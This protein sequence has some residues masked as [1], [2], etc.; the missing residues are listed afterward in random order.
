[1]PRTLTQ[2]IA[3]VRQE[4][5]TETTLHVTDAEI[6]RR[7]V[8]AQYELYDRML[9]VDRHLFATSQNF[10]LSSTPTFDLTTL[11]PSFYQ[12][13]GLE[14]VIGPRPLS[15]HRFQFADRNRKLLL[16]YSLDL[17]A[18]TL[19]IRPST[20]FGG[21]Y[22]LYYTPRLTELA[23]GSDTLDVFTDNYQEFII[24]SAAIRVMSKSEESDPATLTARK[25]ELLERILGAVA[26]RNAEPEQIPDVQS[27]DGDS[28][29]W[30]GG[31]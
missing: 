17:S 30:G 31:F 28:W 11:S 5:D 29:T 15:I 4:S 26:N 2:L 12:M 1:M 3:A 14:L 24:A 9:V 27:Y 22:T 16:S 21:T 7:I 23:S 8:E 13:L 20:N 19:T 10:T 18:N 25:A 6:T